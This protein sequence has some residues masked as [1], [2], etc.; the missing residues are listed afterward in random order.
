MVKLYVLSLRCL[1]LFHSFPPVS[2]IFQRPERSDNVR[3]RIVIIFVLT[4][5]PTINTA[6]YCQEFY[7]TNELFIRDRLTIRTATVS[8]KLYLCGQCYVSILLRANI[9]VIKMS[10]FCPKPI[11]SITVHVK[12]NNVFPRNILSF[13][14]QSM[15]DLPDFPFMSMAL[16]F[17]A[18]IIPSV[19][20]LVIGLYDNDVNKWPHLSF[21][22]AVRSFQ[23]TGFAVKSTCKPINSK[24]DF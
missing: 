13:R 24:T 17:L 4:G 22:G 8:F 16:R 19:R 2:I 21:N 3:Q 10:L 5:L 20:L 9:H 14:K 7:T 12:I 18:S 1:D 15:I 11:N 6:V 23:N